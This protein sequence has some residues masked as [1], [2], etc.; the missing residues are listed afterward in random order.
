M[1]RNE[2]DFLY[3]S[4]V[5]AASSTTN[6]YMSSINIIET[7]LEEIILELAHNDHDDFTEL[8]FDEI[9]S[10]IF[11]LCDLYAKDAFAKGIA[12]VNNLNKQIDVHRN[13]DIQY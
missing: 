13:K 1:H 4:V 11:E 10:V 3:D 6:P 9:K 7:K 2:L 12:F 8:D 5:A